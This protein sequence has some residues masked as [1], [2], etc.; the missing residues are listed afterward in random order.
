[1]E[2]NDPTSVTSNASLLAIV[3]TPTG[4]PTQCK[5]RHMHGFLFMHTTSPVYEL[6]KIVEIFLIMLKKCTYNS[7]YITHYAQVEPI[8]ILI[9]SDIIYEM[10]EKLSVVL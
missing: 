1:M 3:V 2:R 4:E 8:I 7:Q 6:E 5:I 9:E 10:N